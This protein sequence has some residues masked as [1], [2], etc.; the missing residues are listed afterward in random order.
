MAC[1]TDT[2]SEP[3]CKG[4]IPK[5]QNK[6]SQKKETA[7]P[8]LKFHI[9]VSVSNLC[10]PTIDLPLLLQENMWTDPKNI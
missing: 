4:T 8:Q 6:Y 5:I 10:I 1:C 7:Q 3:H 9:H 2:Y